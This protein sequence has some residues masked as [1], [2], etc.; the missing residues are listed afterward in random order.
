MLRAMTLFT[1]D[2]LNRGIFP[3]C[4]SLTIVREWHKIKSNWINHPVAIGAAVGAT[5]LSELSVER[6]AWVLGALLSDGL[7][8]RTAI[9]RLRQTIEGRLRG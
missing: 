6:V 9:A 8:R 4:H 1:A 2:N 5:K 3:K 7:S